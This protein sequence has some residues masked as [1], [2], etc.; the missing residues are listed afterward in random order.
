MTDGTG[1]TTEGKRTLG[2]IAVD[3]LLAGMAAGIL[4]ATA[5]TLIGWLDDVG[6]LE[7]LGRFD[8]A[9]SGSA[10]TGGLFHL[11]MSG[12]YG[13]A[14]ALA[15]HVLVARWEQTRQYGWEIGLTFGLV[16]W[17]AAQFSYLPRLD[18]ALTEVAPWSFALS[19]L[20]YGAGLGYLVSRHN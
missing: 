12:I 13:V 15:Y 3:G 20:I 4:M 19:H 11:A 10:A 8:P 7:M 1:F 2:D 5:L 18:S 16:L 17:L 6:P 14:F 9:N